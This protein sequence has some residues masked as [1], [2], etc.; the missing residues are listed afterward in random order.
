MFPAK[1]PQGRHSVSPGRKPRVSFKRESSHEGAAQQKLVKPRFQPN[2]PQLI[3]NKHK[4]IR[5]RLSHLPH[6]K[7]Y[8]GCR[9]ST[10]L[11]DRLREP[12]S[13]CFRPNRRAVTL[14]AGHRAHHK[15]SARSV[16]FFI[17]HSVPRGT[18]AVWRPPGRRRD[19]EKPSDEKT[20]FPPL[21]F[22]ANLIRKS[23]F[24]LTNH[25]EGRRDA[26]HY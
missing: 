20:P 1:V 15:H 19:P 8:S 16:R 5:S 9:Y 13:A 17:L 4:I 23:D 21:C 12:Q 25:S 11:L 7:C 24:L 3:H 14:A 6:S 26:D 10:R 22:V 18:W 2:F